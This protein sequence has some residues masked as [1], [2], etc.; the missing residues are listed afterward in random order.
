MKVKKEI[1]VINSIPELHKTF[2]LP[3]PEHPLISINGLITPQS[4]EKLNGKPVIYNF[5]SICIKKNFS[6]KV[7]YGQ[8]RYDHDGGVLSFYAP[9]QV[10]AT[11][12]SD[13]DGA[14]GDWLIFHPDLL[15][16]YPLH[17]KIKE[18]GY[19]SYSLNEALHLSA[20]EEQV[21]ENIWTDIK[22]EYQQNIDSFSQDVIVSHLDLLLNYSNR[23]YNRQFI[24]RKK[25]N[26]DML[27]KFEDQLNHYFASEDTLK[28]GLPTVQYFSDRLFVSAQYLS[29]LLKSISGM[30]T[31]QHIH[32][33][34]I[35]VAKEKLMGTNLSVAQ[36][37]YELGFE[38]PQSFNKLFK[39][40]VGMSPNEYRD[41]SLN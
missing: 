36:I 11:E 22:Q 7:K 38:Y 27:A 5:Y 37:A 9:G 21:M 40:K 1:Y 33:K 3:E 34:L 14:M 23:F 19:F 20:K 2:G 16:S 26:N 10:I 15:M 6:G 29:D 13:E 41:S 17:T 30:T 32:H 35:E 4:F 18:Y 25:V 28:S 24:T 12:I 31:Q 39:N 8:T